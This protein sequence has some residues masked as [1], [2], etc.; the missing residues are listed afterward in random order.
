MNACASAEPSCATISLLLPVV[1]SRPR[2]QQSAPVDDDNDDDDDDHHHHHHHVL[3]ATSSP[4][5]LGQLALAE[6]FQATVG[7]LVQVEFWLG[8]LGSLA[9]FWMLVGATVDCILSIELWLR[10][11]E[12]DL[13]E[14]GRRRWELA[15]AR[16]ARFRKRWRRSGG[17][18]GRGRGR[19]VRW[20]DEV[21]AGQELELEKMVVVEVRCEDFK[22][23]DDDGGLVVEKGAG[24]REGEQGVF[25]G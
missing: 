8:L 9:A 21:E 2:P 6:T 11:K 3:S 19:R 15:R 12:N 13:R 25:S 10:R 20:L 23:G 18:G 7:R 22:V 4:S 17:G 16:E 14:R 24:W 5:D 1:P